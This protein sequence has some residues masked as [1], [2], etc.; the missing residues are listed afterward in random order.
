MGEQMTCMLNDI[1]SAPTMHDLIHPV[2]IWVIHQSV[3]TNLIYQLIYYNA[4]ELRKKLMEC[5]HFLVWQEIAPMPNSPSK[6]PS[7]YGE[8]YFTG[9]IFG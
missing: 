4:Q 7:A 1:F 6:F 9:V 8:V 5:Q 3:I 2:S